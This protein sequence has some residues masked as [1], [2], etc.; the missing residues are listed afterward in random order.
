MKY[1]RL[2]KKSF[3]TKTSGFYSAQCLFEILQGFKPL[4]MDSITTLYD[5]LRIA[6]PKFLDLQ[7]SEKEYQEKYVPIISTPDSLK[8][9]IK[10]IFC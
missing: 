5:I 6:S 4:E 2:E 8:L 3:P 7:L 10:L 9:W 1:P